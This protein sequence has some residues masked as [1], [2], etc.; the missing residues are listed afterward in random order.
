MSISI[1]V[2]PPRGLVHP[3]RRQRSETGDPM[4]GDHQGSGEVARLVLDELVV[5][6]SSSPHTNVSPLGAPAY[7]PRVL[8]S[9]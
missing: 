5:A 1:P 7:H 6:A 3:Q 4:E 9:V 8:L 2:Q